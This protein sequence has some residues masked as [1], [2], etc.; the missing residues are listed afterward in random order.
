M[1]KIEQAAQL[2]AILVLALAC[3]V[4]VPLV[5]VTKLGAWALSELVDLWDDCK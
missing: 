4:L 3:T 1:T 5:I 2:V